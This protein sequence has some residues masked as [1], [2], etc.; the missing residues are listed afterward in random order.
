MP[1]DIFPVV[2]TGK[3][4]L[5]KREILF[6][7]D[8]ELQKDLRELKECRKAAEALPMWLMKELE[9]PQSKARRL[10]AKCLRRMLPAKVYDFMPDGLA[11]FVEQETDAA[12]F[13][14]MHL[15]TKVNNTKEVI[16]RLVEGGREEE[17]AIDKLNQD[18]KTAESDDWSAEKILDYAV[19]KAN[20]YLPQETR[21]IV[22]DD[23]IKELLEDK[24]Q[25]LSKEEKNK[26]QKTMLRRL[27]GN[28]DGRKQLLAGYGNAL[29]IGLEALETIVFS[30]VD[31][32]TF[33]KPANTLFVAAKE[34]A[35]GNLA[36]HA[37]REVIIKQVQIAVS[38]LGHLADIVAKA[39]RYAIVSGEVSEFFKAANQHLEEKFRMIEANRAKLIALDDQ[40]AAEIEVR[41][42]E[43]QTIKN[44]NAIPAA[45]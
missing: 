33:G 7:R 42:I 12:A 1:P 11:S 39:P 38:T 36:G 4:A 20:E 3:N 24:S 37:A 31:Y 27:K 35:E 29:S 40:R 5:S 28:L 22:I 2:I 19:E 16:N 13:M 32:V 15:R 26:R 34:M 14:E 6:K 45:N 8:R 23:R 9:L 18:I 25:I 41:A 21:Q 30:Y 10:V 17:S 44:E 43:D